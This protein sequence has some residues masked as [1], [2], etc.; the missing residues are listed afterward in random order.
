MRYSLLGLCGLT[1]LVA[2]LAAVQRAFDW[3]MLAVVMH[4]L[5]PSL[6]W[7]VLLMI[8]F[9]E[10][11][12]RQALFT[13]ALLIF[14]VVFIVGPLLGFVPVVQLV[15]HVGVMV[16]FW[17]IQYFAVVTWVESQ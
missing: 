14:A 8:Q 10:E 11:G 5:F 9:P 13:R 17:G 1:L 7:C 12:M 3:Q 6:V 4:A 2:L 16:F 15:Y